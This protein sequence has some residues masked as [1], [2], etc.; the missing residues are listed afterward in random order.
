MTDEAQSRTRLAAPGPRAAGVLALLRLMPQTRA[1]LIVIAIFLALF[2]A[3]GLVPWPFALLA[4]AAAFAAAVVTQVGAE[5]VR[6]LLPAARNEAG[7]KPVDPDLSV[8]MSRHIPDPCV[9]LDQGSR[10]V[11][12]NGA[13]QKSIGPVDAGQPISF[14]LRAPQVTEAVASVAAGGDPVVVTYLEKVP[15]DRWFEAH[16]AALPGRVGDGFERRVLV[17]LRDLTEAQRIERMRADFV[18]NA[19][20]ELRTPLA[21]LVG[22]IETLQGSARNDAAA[23]DRFLDIMA[24]QCGRMSRLI[25]DLMSLSRIELRAHVLPETT[26]DMAALVRHVADALQPIAADSAVAL[27]IEAPDG[28]LPV[29][30]DHDEMTQV[31]QNLVENAI[32]YGH[33]GKRIVIRAERIT[34]DDVASDAEAP[35]P[36]DHIRISVRDFGP[37]I[38][39]EHLPRLTERFYRVD[40]ATS[41]E[42]GGTGLGLAIVKHILNRH[43]GRLEISSEQGNGAEFIVVLT[44]ARDALDS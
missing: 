1:T 22:F 3:A 10:I 41:R 40:I 21:S 29:R 18:A 14:V 24:Q 5:T 12:A 20:H 27:N 35:G 43:R 25:S 6:P 32:K 13:A 8:E 28:T 26:I 2:A 15:I 37:G 9:I 44:A 16:V 19:S 36:G 42:K 34:V 38:A 39:P 4:G 31:V 33:S 11:F 30:G 23:R 17:Y 7:V